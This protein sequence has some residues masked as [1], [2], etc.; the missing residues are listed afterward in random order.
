MSHETSEIDPKDPLVRRALTVVRWLRDPALPGLAVMVVIALAGAAAIWFAWRG[1]AR[2]I[3]V[4]LQIPQLVSGGLGGVALVG[5]GL[6]LFDLQM[7]RREL[8]QERRHN[9]DILDEIASLVPLAPKI[10]R[11]QRH[12]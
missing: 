11:Q 1:V 4:P 3:Y 8:A 10:K 12:S 7:T 5:L 9:A 6:A 2:T